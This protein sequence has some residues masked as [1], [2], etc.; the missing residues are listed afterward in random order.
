MSLSSPTS[1]T[2]MISWWLQ[3]YKPPAVGIDFSC[4]PC[5]QNLKSFKAFAFTFGYILEV[6]QPIITNLETTKANRY[7]R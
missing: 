7:A 5:P 6:D 4:D 2:N 3:T 1:T